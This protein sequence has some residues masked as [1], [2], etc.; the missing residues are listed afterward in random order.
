M[1]IGGLGGFGGIGS[2][3]SMDGTLASVGGFVEMLRML[4]DMIIE[5]ATKFMNLFNGDDNAA[6]GEGEGEV[7]A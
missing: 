6:A 1:N 2:A 5:Y 7:E 3:G 4:L